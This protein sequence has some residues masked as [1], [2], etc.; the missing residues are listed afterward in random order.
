[1]AQD[2]FHLMCKISGFGIKK[3]SLV[4]HE[5]F[6]RTTVRNAKVLQLL[7]QVDDNILNPA[8]SSLL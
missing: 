4:L 6:Y 1:M 3:P 2:P 7:P 5:P 8:P